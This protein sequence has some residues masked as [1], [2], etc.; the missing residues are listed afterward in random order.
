MMT[1]FGL[2]EPAAML[3]MAA[4]CVGRPDWRQ[5]A[6]READR[7]IAVASVYLNGDRAG[8]FGAAT[9]PEGRRRGAQ[10]A[11]LTA[12][13]RAAREAGCRWLVVETDAEGPGDHNSSLHNMLRAGF[14]RLYERVSWVWHAGATPAP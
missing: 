11:L 4:S 2:D 3:D 6:V 14:E 13:A 8:M 5:F 12:R 7:I 10:S 1:T 9:L